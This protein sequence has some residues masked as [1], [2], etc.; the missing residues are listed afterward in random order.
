MDLEFNEA[1]QAFRDEVRTFLKNKLP[2]RIAEKVKLG[3]RLTKDDMVEWHAILNE[4][5]WLAPNW[6]A[7]HGGARWSAVQNHIFDEESWKP[8]RRA[9]CRLASTC[10]PRC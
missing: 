9:P 7:E 4:K 10:W 3:K 2:S 8:V 5:G 1:D 6:P